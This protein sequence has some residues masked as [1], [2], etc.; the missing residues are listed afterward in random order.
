MS[1]QAITCAL[2]VR[3]VSTAEKLVLLALANYADDRMRCWPSQKR[4]ADDCAMT[5]RGVRKVLKALEAR[6]MLSREDRRRSDGTRQSDFFTL[7]FAGEV[8]EQ[9]ELYSVGQPEPRSAH[10]EPRSS[11]SGTRVQEQAEPRSGLTTFEPSLEEPSKE[12]SLDAREALSDFDRFWAA[13]P[14]RVEKADARK[15]FPAALK[16]AGGLDA[17]LAGIERAAQSRKWIE[18]F[19]PNPAKWLRRDCWLDEPAEIARPPPMSPGMVVAAAKELGFRKAMEQYGGSNR[20]READHGGDQCT[21][22]PLPRL[23]QIPR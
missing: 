7:H 9:A 11:T 12:P 8:T 14:N 3:G 1:V 6:R 23:N 16:R 18:G 2:A 22:V 17:L 13:F 4:L 10:P 5:D 19:I 15:I 21:V 20:N